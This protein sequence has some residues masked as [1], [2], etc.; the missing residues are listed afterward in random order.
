[1]SLLGD[2]QRGMLKAIYHPRE[3]ETL[4]CPIDQRIKKAPLAPTVFESAARV[5]NTCCVI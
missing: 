1:M 2:H 5:S 4:L 3:D